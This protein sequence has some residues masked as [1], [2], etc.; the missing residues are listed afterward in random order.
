MTDHLFTLHRV[1]DYLRYGNK[2]LFCT[3]FDFSKAVDQVWR[4]KLCY[5][6]LNIGASGK[7]FNVIFNMYQNF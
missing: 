2:T 5:K 1:I 3:F 6:V 7:Y 4:S